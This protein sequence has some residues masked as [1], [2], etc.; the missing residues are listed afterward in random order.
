MPSPVQSIN[1]SPSETD[2]RSTREPGRRMRSHLLDIAV[3]LFKSRGLSGVSVAEIAQAADAFP[4]QVTYYF[5]TKEALFVE[6]ACREILYTGEQAERAAAKA[7]TLPLYTR[8]LAESVVASPGL[9]LF[10]EALTLAR[11]RQDLAP[12]I[13]RTFERL[14]SEGDRAYG[15]IRDLRNWPHDD[16]PAL[17]AR[18]FWALALGSVLR[19]AATGVDPEAS[20]RDMLELLD[21]DMAQQAPTSG[22]RPP[23]QMVKAAP[24]DKHARSRT[25]SS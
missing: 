2:A 3:E 10:I 6:A 19:G 24:K 14:H 15:A 23:L 9:A 1:P 7:T 4:S 17:R 8:A 21:S 25:R 5:R 11:R 20:A 13:E 22:A 18:R 12:L 16:D